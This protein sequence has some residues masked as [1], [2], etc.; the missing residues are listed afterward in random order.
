[1]PAY[2]SGSRC[3]TINVTGSAG[4]YTFTSPMAPYYFDSFTETFGGAFEENISFNLDFNGSC[5]T[6]NIVYTT[7]IQPTCHTPTGLFTSNLTPTSVTFNWDPQD[8]FTVYQFWGRRVNGP[9]GEF[10]ATENTISFSQG[11]SPNTTY[12]WKVRILCTDVWTDYTEIQTVTTP[13]SSG[14]N[15]PLFD[16]FDKTENTLTSNVYPNPATNEVNISFMTSVQSQ[17]QINVIDITGRIV[18]TQQVQSDIWET[19]VRLDIADLQNGYYFIEVNDGTI[20]TTSKLNVM[21]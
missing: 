21:K 11:V 18:M 2:S 14:K 5:I 17:V 8:E 16:I 6:E 19:Q 20:S 9:S 4:N 12:E 1:M 10:Y 15:I 3:N 13:P 7:G